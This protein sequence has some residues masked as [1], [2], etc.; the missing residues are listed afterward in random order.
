MG[1]YTCLEE[2]LFGV[3]GA[4]A[5]VCVSWCVPVTISVLEQIRCMQQDGVQRVN[6]HTTSYQ[7]QVHHR[8]RKSLP[9]SLLPESPQ[10]TE[11][12]DDK[13]EFTKKKKKWRVESFLEK[14]Y[15][16]KAFISIYGI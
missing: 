13:S 6:A 1:A 4:V 16:I 14:I 9:P 7:Q 3:L 5:Q 2:Q 8:V 15:K 12:E 10:S 11:T